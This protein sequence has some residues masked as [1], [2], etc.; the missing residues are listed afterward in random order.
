MYAKHRGHQRSKKHV[1]KIQLQTKFAAAAPTLKRK[2]DPGLKSMFLS[3]ASSS[4]DL[5]TAAPPLPTDA[6]FMTSMVSHV[7]LWFADHA[8]VLAPPAKRPKL[9]RGAFFVCLFLYFAFV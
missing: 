7:V 1:D 6:K 2:L 9:T 5:P 4:T 8:L 3:N